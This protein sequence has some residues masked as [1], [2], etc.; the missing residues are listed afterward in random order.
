MTKSWRVLCAQALTA[1]L[2]FSCGAGA[3]E[4]PHETQSL[5]VDT[6]AEL[7]TQWFDEGKFDEAKKLVALLRKSSHPH[8]QVIFLSGLIAAR[9]GRYQAAIDEFRYLLGHD[10]SL[11]RVRLELARAL[12]DAGDFDAAKYHFEIVLGAALPEAVVSNIH[13]YMTTIRHQT[14]FLSVS[15]M[16]VQDSNPSQAT[17]EDSIRIFG[18]SYK[19]DANAK[20]QSA[21]GLAIYAN[22]RYA[23]GEEK[24]FFIRAQFEH[25]DYQSGNS[26]FTQLQAIAGRNVFLGASTLELGIGKILSRYGGEALF[27]GRVL[28]LGHTRPLT[29][30]LFLAQSWNRRNLDYARYD[31]LSGRQDWFLNELRYAISGASTLSFSA[32]LGLNHAADNAYSYRATDFGIGLATETASGFNVAARIAAAN[33]DYQ[34]KSPF[35]DEIRRDQQERM[36]LDITWRRWYW[37]GFA[38]RMTITYAHN[39]S[40]L[41]LYEYS[42][43]S[44]G[45]G[46]T[47]DF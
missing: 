37:N 13:S 10:P 39:H 45:I 33:F 23:F 21:N 42:R 34:D 16:F 11:L 18:K 19:L 28:E 29:Q 12:F 47:R 32:A 41:T 3:S 17:N 36:E 8:P 15:A 25:R 14:S 44:G 4:V 2:L 35:F 46:V 1:A 5:S 30:R 7:A 20:A 38:P 9:E 6:A 40:N 27:D 22:S 43:L 26:D 24:R 31:Y